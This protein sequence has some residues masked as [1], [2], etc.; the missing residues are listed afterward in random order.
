MVTWRKPAK[1]YGLAY[2]ACYKWKSD[3]RTSLQARTTLA[4]EL[5]LVT[6]LF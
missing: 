2:F 5:P 4:T 6:F 1:V 3:S